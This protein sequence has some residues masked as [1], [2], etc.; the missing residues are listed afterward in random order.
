[1]GHIN[2]TYLIVSNVL[3]IKP[4][5]LQIVCIFIRAMKT[6]ENIFTKITVVS[7]SVLYLFIALTYVLFLP[8]YNNQRSA[9]KPTSYSHTVLLTSKKII[10]YNAGKVPLLEKVFKTTI[11]HKKDIFIALLEV[12]VVIT[13]ATIGASA[14]AN[15]RRQLV[16]V[17]SY[18]YTYLHVCALRI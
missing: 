18:R 13:S 17:D 6:C 15:R 16:Y 10:G 7:L 9:S 1:M 4:F 14:A 3:V 5:D 12:A 2:C 8:N 11:Q